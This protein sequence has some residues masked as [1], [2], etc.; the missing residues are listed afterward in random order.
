M[1]SLLLL[2]AASFALVLGCSGTAPVSAQIFGDNRQI[3]AVATKANREPLD[4]LVRDVEHMHPVAMFVLAKRMF[5]QRRGDDATFWLYEGEL[6]WKARLAANSNLQGP[7]GE[8]DR[9]QVFFADISPDID[10][11]ASEDV[12]TLIKIY[13]RVLDWDAAH[14]DDFAPSGKA[15]DDIRQGLKGLGSRLASQ[16]DAIKKA[17]AEK[18]RTCPISGQ[19]AGDDPYTGDGGALFGRPDEMIG[20][21]DPGRFASLHAGTT[22]KSEVVKVLGAPEAWATDTEGNSTLYYG[23]HKPAGGVPGFGLSQRVT[24]GFKF[25]DKKILTAIDLP[26]DPTP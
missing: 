2:R 25:D 19:I 21:Y 26:K 16:A 8:A 9:Y 1:K 12:P 6:R 7:F 5:D 15:K 20:N 4:D 13:D 17:H 14:P 18:R 3:E 24:V 23:Y 22:K 10:W 11:C